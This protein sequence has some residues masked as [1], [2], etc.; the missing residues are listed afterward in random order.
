MGKLTTPD[1]ITEGFDSKADWE[2]SH[3]VKSEKKKGKTFRIRICPKCKSYD[4]GIVLSGNDFEEESNT[5]RLWQCK[6]C[7]WNG[8]NIGERELTED[9]FMEYLDERGE[10]VA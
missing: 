1:W 8:E 10:E 9:E 2:K 6:K 7:K 4:V 3:G 5:G